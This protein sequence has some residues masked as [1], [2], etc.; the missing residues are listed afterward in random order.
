MDSESMKKVNIP[1]FIALALLI[2]VSGSILSVLYVLGGSL[3]P[4]SFRILATLIFTVVLGI[5]TS[6]GIG[7]T[8]TGNRLAAFFAV[9]I[10]V[11]LFSYVKWN[12][13]FGL[14]YAKTSMELGLGVKID[15]FT[16]YKLVLEYIVSCLKTPKYL[17][18][19]FAQHNKLGTWAFDGGAEYMNGALLWLIWAGEFVFIAAVSV[20][21][22]T[23][24]R[25][26]YV[27]SIKNWATPEFIDAPFE[28]LDKYEIER[29]SEGN[30]EDFSEK[31]FQIPG[32][33]KAY[34]IACFS[35]N[36]ENTGF[37]GVYLFNKFNNN[38]NKTLVCA[39]FYVGV[40]KAEA[41]ALL[42]KEKYSEPVEYFDAELD[43]EII[44][45]LEN[46]PGENDNY[47]DEDF[48][49]KTAAE[50][51]EEF[52]PEEFAPKAGFDKEAVPEENT[53]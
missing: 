30:F 45:A 23:R 3:I 38:V 53:L 1:G 39:P 17:L 49:E 18:F 27:P 47:S 20:Y 2:A 37:L 52:A 31:Q 40:E 42:L 26:L 25:G 19:D 41:L 16:D 22:C 43:D 34:H 36:S 24:S 21:E 14:N 29:L 33:K 46:E 9:L 50:T 12:V 35:A 13:F 51:T 6:V 15:L 10:G 48:A 44:Q 5:I 11:I 32:A 8:K 4:A 7:I 28:N